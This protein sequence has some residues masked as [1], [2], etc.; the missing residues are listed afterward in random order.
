MLRIC[1]KRFKTVCGVCYI[2]LT[3][4]FFLV[5]GMKEEYYG[6][7]MADRMIKAEHYRNASHQNGSSGSSDGSGSKRS[8]KGGMPVS[9]GYVK[10]STGSG[11]SA[12]GNGVSMT[13]YSI[14][15]NGKVHEDYKGA[16][17]SLMPKDGI[18][19]GSGPSMNGGDVNM[20]MGIHYV[21]SSSNS[22]ASPKVR[23]KVKVSGGTQT[24]NDLHEMNRHHHQ[25]QHLHHHN[26]LQQQ[27]PLQHHNSAN[28]VEYASSTCSRNSGS[29]SS[30][31]A[32]FKSLSLTTPTATQL[33]QS[34]RERILGSQSLPKGA[35][36]S[37]DYAAILASIQ[38]QQHLNQQVYGTPNASKDRMSRYNKMIMNDGSLSDTGGY[39]NYADIQAFAHIN[40]GNPGGSAY[41]WTRHSTGYASS[42]TSAPNRLIGGNYCI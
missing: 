33:S 3:F 30:Q 24:T 5:L 37:A 36:S 21:P 34:L 7:E 23:T 39:A 40:S 41:P 42:I 29:Y 1:R 20:S 12:G 11:S 17:I 15:V 28:D 25:H 16:H 35:T 19:G 31:S 10:R 38:H 18:Q 32:P 2:K 9:F 8:G 14:P 4:Y 22:A 27:P 26:M 6:K 13:K